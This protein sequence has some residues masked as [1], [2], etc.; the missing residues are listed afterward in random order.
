MILQSMPS[1]LRAVAIASVL[2]WPGSASANDPAAAYPS[3]P[4]KI[5]VATAAGSS[6]DVV[7]RLVA[8]QLSAPLGQAVVVDNRPGAGQTIGV[9]ALAAAEPDG[10]TLLLGSTGA[11][12]I[13]P[14]LYRHLDMSVSRS[15]VPIALMVTIPNVLAIAASVPAKTVGE[16]VAYAKA[17]PGKLSFGASQGTPPHLLGEYVRAKSG[18]E[19][20]YVPYKGG[21]QSLPDLL[22]GRIQIGADGLSLL[23]PHIRDG[24]VRALAVTSATRLPELPDV[25]T[26]A[27][28][29]ID[30]YPAQTWMG[31]VAP[32]GTPRAIVSKL[33]AVVN[34]VL[35]SAAL[36]ESLAKLGFKE[37]PGSPDDFARLIATDA[38]KW[39]AVVAL[40]GAKGE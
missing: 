35:R 38:G 33:N 32:A 6:A 34:D 37:E 18:M 30:G 27:E 3:K 10:H 31:L 25:P 4:V 2:A 14:A 12:A 13:N 39:A 9:K 17:N 1:T 5:I 21:S 8:E 23:L 28:V 22:A 20:V 29:G 24:K 36:R 40:S 7:T 15:F 16:L 11:L 19:I 26:L